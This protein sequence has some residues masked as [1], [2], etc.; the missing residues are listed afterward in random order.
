M[1]IPNKKRDHGL[2]EMYINA[3]FIFN[4]I[5]IKKASFHLVENMRHKGHPGVA[6]HVTGKYH[7]S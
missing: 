2:Q 4:F 5:N 3:H 6:D 1:A 7:S